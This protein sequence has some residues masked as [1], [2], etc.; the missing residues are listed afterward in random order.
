MDDDLKTYKPEEIADQPFPQ[1]GEVTSGESQETSGGVYSP[2][3]IKAKPF[4]KRVIAHETISQSLNTLSRKI[5]GV[6][7]FLKMGAIKIGEYVNGVSGEIK[8]S[9]DGITA[10]NKAG[11]T[12]F[13]IDGDTGDAVFKG[14]V[15]AGSVLAADI[16]GENIVAGTITREGLENGLGSGAFNKTLDVMVIDTNGTGDKTTTDVDV[17]SYVPVNTSAIILDVGIRGGGLPVDFQVWKKGDTHGYGIIDRYIQVAN[18]FYYTTVIVGV[19]SNLKFSYIIGDT[20]SRGWILEARLV[21]YFL[22]IT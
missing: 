6:F 3:T 21:G 14:T 19:D 8:I 7:E 5:S 4:P 2:T 9:P 11:V 20:G 16:Y 17:S 1:E 10:K 15:Q 18:V 12:T 22:T 13:A